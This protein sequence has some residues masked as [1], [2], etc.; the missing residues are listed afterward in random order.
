MRLEP[1]LL[2]PSLLLFSFRG[3]LGIPGA[4]PPSAAAALGH[5]PGVHGLEE[6]HTEPPVSAGQDAPGAGTADLGLRIR[7]GGL[8]KE[9]GL[10]LEVA[11]IDYQ[12]GPGCKTSPFFVSKSSLL[13]IHSFGTKRKY[14]GGRSGLS[15]IS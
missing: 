5:C 14:L 1:L 6:L 15:P 4:A 2:F 3:Q 11:Q 13:V 7:G 9:M 8:L 10:D 12:G